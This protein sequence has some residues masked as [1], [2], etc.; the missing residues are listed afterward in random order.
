MPFVR[1]T[2]LGPPLTRERVAILRDGMTRLMHEVMRKAIGGVAILVEQVEGAW[3]IAGAPVAVAAQ[4]DVTIG[5]GTNTVDEKARFMAEAWEL[6]RTVL[7]P[8]L[9]EETYIVVHELDTRS[10][11]RGGWS[12]A[13]RDRR[14]A[15]V[16]PL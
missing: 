9:R 11:G 16:P 5:A 14:G 2:V 15:A 4:V 6:L 7:G 1:I 8:E 3:S 12:R 10:Y 13:E